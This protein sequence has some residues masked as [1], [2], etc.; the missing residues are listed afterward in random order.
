M[1]KNILNFD[2]PFQD[3][4]IY[5]VVHVER[6]IELLILQK[7]ILSQ[8]QQWDDPFENYILRKCKK[9]GTVKLSYAAD[10]FGQCWSLHEETDAMW[11]IYAPDKMG[12]K[13]KTSVEK[14]F[15]QFYNA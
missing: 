11:R 12:V 5:R 7:L 9:E 2:E 4:P 6:L 15:S 8:P 13:I 10:I 1:R 3:V 14:L